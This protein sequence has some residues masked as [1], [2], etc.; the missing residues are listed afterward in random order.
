VGVGVGA[1]AR[2]RGGTEGRERGVRWGTVTFGALGTE[3]RRR[4]GKFQ[5][6]GNWEHATCTLAGGA[7]QGPAV[8]VSQPDLQSQACGT[9]E[10]NGGG[11]E[12]ALRQNL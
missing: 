10:A 6:H 1:A 9:P 3:A 2:G 11:E 5:G 8:G 12:S 7:S 4:G